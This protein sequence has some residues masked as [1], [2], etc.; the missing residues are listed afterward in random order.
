MTARGNPLLEA[1]IQ[2][3]SQLQT[4]RDHAACRSALADGAQSSSA[5]VSEGVDR[6]RTRS[7]RCCDSLCNGPVLSIDVRQG[8]ELLLGASK[9]TIQR[10]PGPIVVRRAGFRADVARLLRPVARTGLKRYSGCSTSLCPTFSST[11]SRLNRSGAY[12]PAA[13]MGRRSS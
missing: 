11:A 10:K 1:S 8:T 5:N 12:S 7:R 2:I 4:R 3:N 13:H 9:R 6:A